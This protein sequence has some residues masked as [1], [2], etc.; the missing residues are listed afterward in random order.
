[1]CMSI[2]IV[3]VKREFRTRWGRLKILKGGCVTCVSPSH[4]LLRVQ[5]RSALLP[6]HL[7]VCVFWFWSSKRSELAPLS[8]LSQ[9]DDLVL[10]YIFVFSVVLYHL[11]HWIDL[12]QHRDYRINVNEVQLLAVLHLG[13][14][15]MAMSS[16]ILSQH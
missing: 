14:W 8:S 9:N 13:D 11:N 3:V 16:S 7:C 10:V 5:R 6:V 12:S 4:P 15:T 1:M 2:M